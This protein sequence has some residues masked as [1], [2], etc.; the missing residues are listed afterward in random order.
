MRLQQEG[1]AVEV[2][3]PPDAAAAGLGRSAGARRRCSTNL[4]DNAIKYSGDARHIEIEL[5][6]RERLRHA[7]RCS[8]QGPGIAPDEQER[9]F[10]KFYRVGNGLVH[11]AK[12]SGLGLAI[13]KHVV[14][15]HGGRVVVDSRPARAARSPSSCRPMPH[16]AAPAREAPFRVLVVE[17]D[18]AMAVALRDGFTY[19]GCTVL[20]RGRRRRRPAPRAA[21]REVDLII[22]DVMLPKLSGLDV[23]ARLRAARNDVPII[24]LTARS[25]EADKVQG[26]SARRRRLRHQAVQLRRAAGARAR[27]CCAARGAPAALETYAFGDCRL[28]FEHLRATRAGAPLDLSPREFAILACLI[29]RRGE[30]VTREQLLQQVWGYDSLPFTRT[31]DMHIAKLRRKIEPHRRRRPSSSSP[32]TASATSSSADASAAPAAPPF[33]VVRLVS[34]RTALHSCLELRDPAREGR[35]GRHAETTGDMEGAAMISQ[36]VAATPSPPSA[37]RATERAA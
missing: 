28:D 4:L 9:I 29:A 18:P 26:L 6:Q 12:G 31:V 1:F 35:L 16:D 2:R 8:D 10:E 36:T 14:E 22:L 24:M 5:G 11:D 15:A 21:R 34:A 27:R 17:D 30:V 13:V 20:H 25:Q 33:R 19:E 7:S 32:S 23:C 3:T 37:R